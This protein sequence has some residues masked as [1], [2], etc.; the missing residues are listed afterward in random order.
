MR[1][2]S[3]V[4]DRLYWMARYMERAE[5]TARVTQAYTHLVM[6]IPEGTELGWDVLVHILDGQPAFENQ[7]RAYNEQN[8]LK[9]LIA[10]EDN[11][12]SIRQSVKAARENVRTTRDQ[13]P[14]DAWEVINE[15]Y[16]YILENIDQGVG[17]RRGTN[18]STKSWVAA[19]CSM[20]C[21]PVA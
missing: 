16:R 19:R 1:L 13:I 21:W 4:A 9:F 12:G 6:D 8:V 20:V 7:Y 10:D 5:D 14:T 11:F 18:S 17:K 2:L 3:R 15:L